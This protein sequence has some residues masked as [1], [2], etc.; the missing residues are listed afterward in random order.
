MSF[1]VNTPPIKSQ[2]IKTKLIPW[3][4][5]LIPPDFK[6]VWVEPFMGTGV[7]AFN[8]APYG[9]VLCDTNPHLVN[10][11]L[12]IASG[13]ITPEVVNAYLIK[14]GAS[15]LHKGEDHYYFIRDRFNAEYSP[16]D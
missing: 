5:S 14:E 10:F 8:L 12:A 6:G 11:Y 16:F 3:I 13:E 2:G 1:K 4:S 9:A 7:V 15:L